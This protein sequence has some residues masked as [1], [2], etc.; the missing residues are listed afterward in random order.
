[1]EKV[2]KRNGRKYLLYTCK[3]CFDQFYRRADHK[4]TNYCKKCC[5]VEHRK[6]DLE[7]YVNGC[8]ERNYAKGL[9]RFHYDRMYRGTELTSG[10][11]GMKKIN[12]EIDDN[13]CFICTSHAPGKHGYRHMVVNGKKEYIHRLV[14]K[15]C[16]GDIPDGLVVRHKCDIPACINPE[17]LEIGTHQQNMNDSVI[18]KRNAFGER[19]GHAKLKEKDVIK[20]LELLSNGMKQKDVAEMYKVNPS[21]IQLISSGKNWRHITCPK[22]EA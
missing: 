18:R 11:Y 19:N 3:N 12:F 20:V 10:Y 22:T 21:T 1:M 13:G 17:H 4:N 5:H 7:C 2:I 15:E 9:C 16:F 14:Y 6:P 8:K